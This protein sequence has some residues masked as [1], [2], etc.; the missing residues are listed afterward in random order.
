MIYKFVSAILKPM[1]YIFSLTLAVGF[2]FICFRELENRLNVPLDFQYISEFL[3]SIL[4]DSYDF[5]VSSLGVWG[6][7]LIRSILNRN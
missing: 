5:D 7:Q 4:P 6:K 3:H 1:L 2:I